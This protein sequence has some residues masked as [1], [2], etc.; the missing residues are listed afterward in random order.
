MVRPLGVYQ[1]AVV[2][3][4]AVS[5]VSCHSDCTSPLPKVGVPTTRARSWSWSAPVM[6][7][8]AL[9]V[10]PFTSTTIGTVGQSWG[11]ASLNVRVVL[12]ARPH[13]DRHRP[14][15][16]RR[17]AHLEGERLLHAGPPHPQLHGRARLAAQ[18]LH[19]LVVLPALGRAA[20]ERDDPVAGLDAGA[21]G[22]RVGERRH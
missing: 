14:K 18:L 1:R 7:S 6:I 21:L 17:A 12:G 2:S 22:G 10:P 4:S 5:G 13:R 15:V 20:F 9:A 16:D 3:F 8:A 11:L 19:R